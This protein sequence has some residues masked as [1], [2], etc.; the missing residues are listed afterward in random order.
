[1]SED[2]VQCRKCGEE[3]NHCPPDF[4]PECDGICPH[5]AVDGWQD[6]SLPK[7]TLQVM[8]DYLAHALTVKL[9]ELMNTESVIELGI[10]QG[11]PAGPAITELAPGTFLIRK[12]MN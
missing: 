6:G 9:N 8:K 12:C 1:M 2:T 4:P 3:T 7:P 11:A 5:C 10:V